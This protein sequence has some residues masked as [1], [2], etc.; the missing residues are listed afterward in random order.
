MNGILTELEFAYNYFRTVIFSLFSDRNSAIEEGKY[1]YSKTGALK[2]KDR[3]K[4]SKLQIPSKTSDISF[5]HF[6]CYAFITGFDG[7]MKHSDK[8][9]E[10]IL[11][12]ALDM[13][14]KE[15]K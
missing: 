9:I 1:N 13:N 4:L 5:E 10:V 15:T 8:Q 6:P 7:Y 2:F 14:R 12:S 11:F 3:I